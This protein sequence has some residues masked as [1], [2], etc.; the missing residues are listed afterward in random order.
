MPR[1]LWTRRARARAPSM[2]HR[3]PNKEPASQRLDLSRVSR[4]RTDLAR[5]ILLHGAA[6]AWLE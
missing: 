6:P 2:F 5:I 4:T 1:L 3:P